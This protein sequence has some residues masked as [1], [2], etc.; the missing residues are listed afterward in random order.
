MYAPDLFV[1]YHFA[2]LLGKT[3]FRKYSKRGYDVEFK[4]VN[5]GSFRRRANQEA[6]D[7]FPGVAWWTRLAGRYCPG[8]LD[9]A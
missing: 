1:N 6:G 4:V 7:T 8:G 3:H 5:S 2:N 9:P